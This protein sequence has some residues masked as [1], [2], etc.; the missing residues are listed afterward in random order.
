M[1]NNYQCLTNHASMLDGQHHMGV[2]GSLLFTA[3]S[4]GLIY[5]DN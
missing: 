4:S 5:L 1:F 2:S 3:V